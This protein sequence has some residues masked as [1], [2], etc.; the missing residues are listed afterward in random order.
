MHGKEEVLL[1]MLRSVGVK[2]VQIPALDTDQFGTFSGEVNREDDPIKTLRNKCVLANKMT[3]ADMV[4]ASEGSFGAHPFM[5]FVSADE[6]LLMLKDFKN[7]IEI[8]VKELSTETN[9]SGKEISDL[10][11]LQNFANNAGFPGHALI[12]KCNGVIEKGI[13]DAKILEETYWRFKAE[14]HHKIMVETDMRAMHNP[15]RMKVISNAA[16]KLKQ[17]ILATCPEC[18]FPNFTVKELKLG[19]PCGLCQMPT[20]SVKNEIKRCDHC[21][22]HEELPAEKNYQAPMY[23]NYCNP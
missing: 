15:T 23:C 21:G 16:S 13:S 3:G 19:L 17:A 5:P 18:H 14:S 11:E 4:I 20:E 8:V 22:K 12:L 6:E 2:D 10:D 9:F 1:P 7:S